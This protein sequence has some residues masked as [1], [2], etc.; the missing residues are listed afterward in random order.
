MGVFSV[1]S[2]FTLVLSHVVIIN[3]QVNVVASSSLNATS[4]ARMF[5][6]LPP[7]EMLQVAIR[8]QQIAREQARF[9]NSQEH[10]N[11]AITT[12]KQRLDENVDDLVDQCKSRR[13]YAKSN[14]K[15]TIAHSAI[16]DAHIHFG[17]LPQKDMDLIINATNR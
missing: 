10:V 3:N 8:L 17:Y 5:A 13:I 1:F 14:I 4:I 12:I 7:E 15:E 16:T 6:H 2:V 11:K 9:E